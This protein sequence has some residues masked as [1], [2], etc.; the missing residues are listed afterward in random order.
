VL[1]EGFLLSKVSFA[2]DTSMKDPCITREQSLGLHDVINDQGFAMYYRAISNSVSHLEVFR[3]ERV[4]RAKQKDGF[5]SFLMLNVLEA[6]IFQY[7]FLE[8]HN[9]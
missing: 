9:V 2:S 1:F 7:D 8:G 5:T 4:N 3:Y 6:K